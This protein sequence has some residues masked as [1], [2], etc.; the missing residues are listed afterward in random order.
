MIMCMPKENELNKVS[1]FQERCFPRPFA[2]NEVH[3]TELGNTRLETKFVKSGGL[4]PRSKRSKFKPLR[5]ATAETCTPV[6]S[7][8][9]KSC[10]VIFDSP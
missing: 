4:F 10:E 3:K 2:C 6:T 8:T 7:P 9:T 1:L 5:C